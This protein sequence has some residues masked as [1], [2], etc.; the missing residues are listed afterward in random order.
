MEEW[1]RNTFVC[2]IK[3]MDNGYGTLCDSFSFRVEREQAD[4]IKSVLVKCSI[5]WFVERFGSASA[6]PT[7]ETLKAVDPDDVMGWHTHFDEWAR[8]GIV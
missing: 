8:Q 7:A 1:L 5:P 3:D 6:T 4:G 2:G